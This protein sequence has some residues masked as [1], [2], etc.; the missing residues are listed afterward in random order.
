MDIDYKK[1][2]G[3]SKMSKHAQKLFVE[4]Y[5]KQT[6][7]MDYKAKLKWLPVKVAEH[8]DCIKVYFTNSEWLHYY[9]NGTWG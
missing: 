5:K 3:F 2:K 4:T 7:S 1:I 6:N 8:K 9:A